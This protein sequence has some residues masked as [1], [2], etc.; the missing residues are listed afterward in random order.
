MAIG[1]YHLAAILSLPTLREMSDNYMM[2]GLFRCHWQTGMS[3]VMRMVLD[4]WC[5]PGESTRKE[6]PCA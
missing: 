2:C 3:V 4:A 5:K 6:P 1:C